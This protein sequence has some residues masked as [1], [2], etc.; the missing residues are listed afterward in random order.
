VLAGNAVNAHAASESRNVSVEREKTVE[1]LAV[2]D[3]RLIFVV[4]IGFADTRSWAR[5]HF[6]PSTTPITSSK[7]CRL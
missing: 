7:F 1:D 6:D 4:R 3:K 5:A 2:P